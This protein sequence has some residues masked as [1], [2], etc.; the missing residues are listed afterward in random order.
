M[1]SF[2][3]KTQQVITIAKKIA[4]GH[5]HKFVSTE[6]LLLGLLEVPTCSAA[7]FIESFIETNGVD[8]DIGQIC[9]AIE[10]A[11]KNIPT[12]PSK[13]LL[14]EIPFSPK[15]KQVMTVAGV[16]AKR[17]NTN[18]V[19]S[20]LLL[21][22]IIDEASGVCSTILQ[23]A[24]ID[25][26]LI[27]A[28]LLRE[29]DPDLLEDTGRELEQ[30][31]PRMQPKQPKNQQ[32][33]NNESFIS[34][35]T[36]DL[37]EK[38]A[39]GE[40][41]PV[42]GREEE[43]DRVLQI[44]SRKQKNNPV[45]IGEPG[46]GKTAVV[47]GIAQRLV[48]GNVPDNLYTKHIL[49]LDMALMVAGTVYR[50]QFEERLKGLV[51]ELIE[52]KDCII[53]I[54]ELHTIVGAG[55]TTGSL[56]ASNILKPALSRGEI[57]CI[58]ATTIDEHRKYI[59][60]DSALERRFQ[61][62]IVEEPTKKQTLEI[63]R[64]LKE[65]YEEFHRVKYTLQSL[66]CIV[67]CADKYIPDRNFP[68]KAIDILDELGAKTRF[69][70]FKIPEFEKKYEDQLKTI[71]KDKEKA[72][73]SGE[74]DSALDY[75]NQ[76]TELFKEYEEEFQEW[77]DEQGQDITIHEDRV[78]DYIFKSVGIPI[79]I[80]TEDESRKLKLLGSRIKRHVIGQDTAVNSIVQCIQRSRIGLN[81]PNRPIGSFLFLGTTGVGK[82]FIA[83]NIARLL[84]GSEKSLIQVD[85]SELMEQHSV[86]KLIG[87]PPGYVGH[88]E[89]NNFLEQIRKKPHSVILFD[90]IEKAHPDV[91]HILLQV[92]E[93]GCLTDGSGRKINFK[94]TIIILT[95][96]IG[97][98]QINSKEH[99]GFG[100]VQSSEEE[101]KDYV[102]K[103]LKGTLPPEFINRL[104]DI[105]V[106]ET[107]KD[108]NLKKIL[109]IELQKVL[110]RAKMS[111]K[112]KAVAYDDNV[113]DWILEQ[114]KEL[115]YG[116]RPLK[117]L[118]KTHIQDTLTSFYIKNVGKI[119]RKDT[120]D[121]TISN[122]KLKIGLG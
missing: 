119:T 53:F 101:V 38:A 15:V 95:G 111:L 98:Q 2:S 25:I 87:S 109:K 60:K 120:L 50:G 9:I 114:N 79:N 66:K 104:D 32:V 67:D 10:K 108:D 100:L 115:K 51:E 72:V 14:D 75:R 40:L 93:E 22:G 7:V 43:I 80:L 34:Q 85:M 122:D 5:Q 21:L 8:Y 6:H 68:D 61:S 58:G 3:I 42:I 19:N 64:G 102:V 35:F 46:V 57:S 13:K 36:V 28:H 90:E 27:K 33:P 121:I 37:T 78:R 4:Q 88:D 107:L 26:E 59:E 1:L 47:E 62:V 113:L 97:A 23:D 82:T 17:A 112:V 54:D 12:Y 44:L 16:F 52:V 91:L 117:R 118:I 94:N 86:S 39:K 11:L 69:Q 29:I 73:R 24:G 110:R 92:F 74:L 41:T 71:I 20:L 45:L 65:S 77:V 49:S 48:S 30:Q 89:T 83:K 105:V 99:M 70:A 103:E 84:Y 76:E 18:E 31:A 96:N 63:L 116:A 81:D 55:S 56:D 106:F